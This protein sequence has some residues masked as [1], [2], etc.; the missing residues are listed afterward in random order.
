MEA[1]NL[2]SSNR[3]TEKQIVSVAAGVGDSGGA[4]IEDAHLTPRELQVLTPEVTHGLPPLSD[5]AWVQAFQEAVMP[6]KGALSW[7]RLF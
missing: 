2:L 7:L 4:G 5:P 6:T 1:V 3:Y